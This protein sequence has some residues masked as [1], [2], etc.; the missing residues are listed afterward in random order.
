MK[1]GARKNP[2]CEMCGICVP[3]DKIILQISQ[4][5]DV[6]AIIYI[7]GMNNNKVRNNRNN[8]QGGNL[9]YWCGSDISCL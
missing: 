3:C 7:L 1:E 4:L 2:L 5:N 8:H 9:N 6:K